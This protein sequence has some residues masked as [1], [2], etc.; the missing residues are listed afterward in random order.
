MSRNGYKLDVKDRKILH[1]LDRN[2][3]QANSEIG[4]RTRLS[5]EVVKY[6]IDRMIENDIINRFHTI[7][8]YF[9]LGFFKYKLY[10]SLKDV[11]SKK[12]EEISQYFNN[13]SKTEWIITC[14][15]R[16]DMIVSFIVRNVN[17]F[18]DEIQLVMNKFSQYIKE[19]AVT[20]TLYLAHHRR[21]YLRDS[22]MPERK[23]IVFHTSADKQEGIE[24]IDMKILKIIS[25][26]ARMP[27]REIA[28]K[29]NA[30]PRVV[31]YRIKRM[32]KRYIILAYKVHI[33]PKKMGNIFCK[34]IIYLASSERERL[35]QFVRYCSSIP[36]AVWP[37]RVMGTWDFEIDLELEN[38][39]RFQG[40]IFDLKEKFSDIIQKNEFIIVTKEFK[41][42]FF[43]GMILRA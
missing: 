42:E 32:E 30:T 8:N 28:E 5:K 12:I 43:P 3:R 31:Q 7:V 16:W 13:H 36:Q 41:L 9:K 10:L 27:V 17:E 11:N 6:R 35:N 34:A 20:S 21:E 19:K 2:C 29:I 15:G 33:E 18:D 24:D 14:T 25:N 22:P 40:I 4:R 38:Y 23:A 26:N 37:Q 1:E 39:D